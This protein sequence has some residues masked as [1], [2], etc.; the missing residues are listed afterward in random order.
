[1]L[2][3]FPTNTLS[4]DPQLDA[5]RAHFDKHGAALC[6]AAGLINGE[7]G[8]AR[9]LRLMSG[10][11]E[12]SRLDRAAR[13]KLVEL[14][15]L[16]SLDPFGDDLEPDLSSWPLLD[17]ASPVVEEICLLTDRLYDLLVEIGELDDEQKALALAHGVQDAA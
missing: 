9:V 7:A 6:N 14:H 17:P 11:R 13:R 2:R 15:R 12:A 1:M 10:L 3:K 8:T 16:L 4:A 5:V